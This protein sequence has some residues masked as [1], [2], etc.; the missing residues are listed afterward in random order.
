ML[1]FPR[2]G[3]SFL[4][5]FACERR[6]AAAVEFAIIATPFFMLLLGVVE[7]G[8]LFMASTTLDAAT[9]NASR[10]IR[11]GQ[12]QL[13]G[14]NTAAGFKSVVCANM[15]WLSA[16]DCSANVVVDVRTFATFSSISVTPPITNGALDPSKTSF[17]SGTSCSIVLVRVFYPYTLLAPLLEPGM[18]NLGATQRLVTSSAAFRN[19]DFAGITPC[20]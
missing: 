5:R 18:P 19:E 7:L 20:S 1:G 15:S 4:R 14:T 12:L 10:E 3:L 6:G 9:F 16:S 11:T 8:M 2:R 13:Y 17:D